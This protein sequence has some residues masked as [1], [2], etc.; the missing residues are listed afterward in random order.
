MHVEGKNIIRSENEI[1]LGERFLQERI[2][3]AGNG[4]KSSG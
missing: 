3:P 2:V 4:N 1:A